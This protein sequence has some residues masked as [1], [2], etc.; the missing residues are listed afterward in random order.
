MAEEKAGSKVEAIEEEKT[1]EDLAAALLQEITALPAEETQFYRNALER[2]APETLAKE[3]NV[4]WFLR[5]AKNDAKAATLRLCAFWK[6]RH[7]IFGPDRAYRPVLDLRPNHGALTKQDLSLLTKDYF[8][9]LP[10]DPKGRVVL[11]YNTP[12]IRDR[13]PSLRE[14]AERVAFFVFTSILQEEATFTK[15]FVAITYPGDYNAF[16]LRFLTKTSRKIVELLNVFP[17][18]TPEIHTLT[19]ESNFFLRSFIHAVL[20]LDMHMHFR[21]KEKLITLH[22]AVS[23]QD[24]ATELVKAGFCPSGLPG[25]V[26]G[27]YQFHRYVE[28]LQSSFSLTSPLPDFVHDK[29]IPTIAEDEGVPEDFTLLKRSIEIIQAV[30]DIPANEKQAFVEA[31]RRQAHD[32]VSVESDPVRYLRMDSSNMNAARRLVTYW[33]QRLQIFG[34]ENAFKPLNQ[35]GEECAL[36]PQDIELLNTQF[37]VIAHSDARGRSVLFIDHTRLPDDKQQDECLDEPLRVLFYMLAVLSENDNS[38]S[39]SPIIVEM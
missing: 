20:A 11:F 16:K 8:Y 22:V 5:H 13:H 6:A 12:C 7:R 10:N 34:P 33:E 32:L 9:R 4:E 26:G 39:K 1:A 3:A 19:H 23:V 29:D 24:M 28:L 27:S 38:Q 30:S 37:C 36:Q 15:G 17:F 35:T 25:S 14:N 21:G 2:A 18:A 31:T